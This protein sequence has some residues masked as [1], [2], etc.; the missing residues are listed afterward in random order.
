MS[1]MPENQR[2][3]KLNE[4]ILRDHGVELEQDAFILDFGCGSGRH[5][6]EYLDR[7]YRNVFG[8]DVQQYLDARYNVQNQIDLRN[9]ADEFRFCLDK[10]KCIS[11]IPFP[12]NYFD[13]IYSYSV[14][15]HVLDQRLAWAEIYRVLKPGGVSLH[16][17]AAKWRPIE[18][19]LGIPFGGALRFYVYYRFWTLLG[20]GTKLDAAYTGIELAKKYVEFART[21]LCYLT[22]RELS[23]VLKSQFQNY[24]YASESFIRW[25]PGR[26]RYLY[27][28]IKRF[29]FLEYFFRSLHTR[30]ILVKKRP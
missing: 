7:G 14:F 23:S 4:H 2:I 29:P 5:V 9:S 20:I 30:V 25:S 24:L 6:Y 1:E 27:P 18:P 11:K 8:Y 19:H 10:Q 17:F 21:G 15:E 26:S 13:F 28:W 3:V 12:D 16:C 22:G